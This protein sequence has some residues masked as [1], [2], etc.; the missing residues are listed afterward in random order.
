MDRSSVGA[1]GSMAA[2]VAMQDGGGVVAAE[3]A[4]GSS[5]P[6]RLP[7]YLL[8]RDREDRWTFAIDVSGCK[9]VFVK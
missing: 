9:Q 7:L 3:G 6:R 8:G 2:E 5:L 1:S 4:G